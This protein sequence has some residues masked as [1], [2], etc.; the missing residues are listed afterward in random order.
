MGAV[1]KI[2]TQFLSFVCI[3]VSLTVPFSAAAQSSS[4]TVTQQYV[5][6][7]NTPPTTPGPLTA[8]TSVHDQVALVWGASTDNIMLGGY[9]VFRDGAQIATTTLNSYTDTG[10]T[11]STTY[12]YYVI[13]FDTDFNFSSSSN[14][15]FATT[16]DAIL[17][18]EEK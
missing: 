9:Q 15:A 14:I 2:T 6:G 7:D 8:T 10:L 12:A 3:C 18:E 5:S 1:C 13:A 4:F 11:P 16:T 17:D